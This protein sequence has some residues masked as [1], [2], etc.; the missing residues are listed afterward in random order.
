MVHAF[1]LAMRFEAAA[2]CVHR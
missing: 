1:A 2:G